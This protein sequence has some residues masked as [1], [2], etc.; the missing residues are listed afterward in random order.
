MHGGNIWAAARHTGRPPSEWL[1]FSASINPLGPPPWL[2]DAARA[3]IDHVA[4]YPDPDYQD[5]TEAAAARYQLQPENIFFGAGAADLIHLLIRTLRPPAG[6]VLA[7]TFSRYRV[8]LAEAGS[9]VDELKA[10]PGPPDPDCLAAWLRK[11]PSGAMVILCHPN[12]PTGRRLSEELLEAA[13]GQERI[14]ILVDEAFLDFVVEGE[15][16]LQR[17]GAHPKLVVLRSLTKLYAIPGLRVGWLA[18]PAGVISRLADHR[19]P[20]SIDSPAAA[21]GL[22]ALTGRDY[23]LATQE[24]VL[25][26][27]AEAFRRL[28]GLGGRAVPQPSDA[29]YFLVR[30]RDITGSTLQSR[31]LPFGILVRTCADFT[32]L[33]D[34]YIRLAVRPPAQLNRLMTALAKCLT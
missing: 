31:L 4:H 32:G 17:A 10:W 12:N 6:L 8:A 33:D 1:D 28:D 2:I 3:G 19:I 11:A 30:L 14:W 24:A 9:R 16:L 7:P 5:L 22:A 21:A 26:L 25:R 34:A 18:G 29:N 23:G 27:R 20:W 13:L 15:T